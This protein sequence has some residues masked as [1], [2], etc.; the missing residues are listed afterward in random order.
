V[1]FLN[2]NRFRSRPAKS[3]TRRKSYGVF[4]SL[5]GSPGRK[6]LHG[7]IDRKLRGMVGTRA[8]TRLPE[9]LL[10]E[11][12]GHGSAPDC[13]ELESRTI[14]RIGSGT[15][16]RVPVQPSGEVHR[17]VE[18]LNALGVPIQRVDAA[19]EANRLSLHV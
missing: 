4:I 8:L 15:A 17:F 10:V 2:N 6:R 19:K 11:G 7:A 14:H 13:Y 12:S 5:G 1:P 3:L 18:A 9:F 16:V